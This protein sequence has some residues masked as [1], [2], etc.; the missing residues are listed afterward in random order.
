MKVYKLTDYNNQ[1]R[2]NTQWGEGVT[3]TASGE[4][5]LC[6]RGWLHAYTDPRLAVILNP[7]HTNFSNPRLWEA[8]AGGEFKHDKQ[9]KMGCTKLTTTRE[10]PLPKISSDV[11]T[12]FAIRCALKVYQEG[13]FVV[14]AN[15]WLSGEDRTGAAAEAAAEAAWAARAARVAWAAEA[16]W[17]VAQAAA[18][19]AEATWAATRAARAA[20]AAT[21]AARAARAA[22]WAAWA[23]ARVAD[24]DLIQI[25]NEMGV[26]S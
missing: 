23:A 10:I 12:E 21:W 7:I 9:L 11:K 19:A 15:K 25:L 4:G 26:K 22:T 17:A 24:I 18:R 20:R 1:T 3:H 5:E 6:S 2:N 13:S 8:E 16:A 14:W